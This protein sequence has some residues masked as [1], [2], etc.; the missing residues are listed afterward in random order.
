MNFHEYTNGAGEV[1]IL[2]RMPQN[3]TTYGG[4]IWPSGVGTV[5]KCPNWNP[6][7]TCGGGLHG[8]AW[9]FGL[10]D[11][12]DYDIIG[13]IWL[14]IGAQPDDVVGELNG[15][16]KCK[17]RRAVIR[18]EGSFEDAR[19][20]VQNGFD[21][22]VALMSK[23]SGNYSTAASSGNSSTAA[24]FPYSCAPYQERPFKF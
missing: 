3:R 5:V 16:A 15:S 14:V 18:L 21:A 8:W 6:I 9:G 20:A 19:Q 12:C 23:D 7:P 22:C 11:G 1:L 24:T 17:C 13:D 2:R 4:F 10:G